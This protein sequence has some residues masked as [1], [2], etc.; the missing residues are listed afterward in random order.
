[1]N[2]QKTEGWDIVL[3]QNTERETAA[4]PFWTDKVSI[5]DAAWEC[6]A[7][8][9]KVQSG[10]DLGR[11]FIGLS[12]KVDGDASASKTKIS[13]CEKVNRETDVKPHFKTRENFLGRR[14][15][16][17]AWIVSTGEF[18]D[19]EISITTLR[20][21][22][23]S[24]SQEALEAYR[25][26]QNFLKT[27]ILRLPRSGVLPGGQVTRTEKGPAPSSTLLPEKES[28]AEPGE[29]PF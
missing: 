21:D 29:I 15:I 25:Q 26:I 1:M 16:F 24:L 23:V 13:L 17:S 9:K 3:S 6:A 19:L 11:P 18:S 14:C 8:L 10:R 20:L 22:T 5:G 28:D 7:W 27:S 4:Q 2:T 12:L